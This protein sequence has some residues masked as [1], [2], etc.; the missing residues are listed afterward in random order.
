MR[1][2]SIRRSILLG[3]GVISVGSMMIWPDLAWAEAKGMGQHNQHLHSV[4]SPEEALAKLDS[5]TPMPLLPMMANHQKQ[6]MRDHLQAI[7]ELMAA[8][9]MK[10]FKGVEQAAGK[11]GTSPEM[12]MSCEMMGAGAPGYTDLGLSMHR[13]ADTVVAA[14]KKQD[15]EMVLKNASL[16]LQTC[17]TCHSTYRQQI[18]TEETWKAITHMDAPHSHPMK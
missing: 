3:M 7:Q 5:R 14:A 13:T 8:L 11:L 16:T 2:R 12:T 10:D 17:T 15:L 18:V 1:N 6:M 4:A 9:A